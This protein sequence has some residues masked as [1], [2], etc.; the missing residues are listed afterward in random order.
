MDRARCAATTRKALNPSRSCNAPAA[1]GSREDTGQRRSK[2]YSLARVIVR[3]CRLLLAISFIDVAAWAAEAV[4]EG[5]KGQWIERSD[6][7][8]LNILFD[9]ARGIAIA[10]SKTGKDGSFARTGVGRIE[11]YGHDE[12][13]RYFVLEPH[14]AASSGLPPRLYYTFHGNDLW[15]TVAEGP[16]KGSHHLIRKQSK[17][18]GDSR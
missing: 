7:L 5:L 8:E 16:M 2:S 6:G 9:E 1:T 12:H 15:L 4:S 3:V 18:S 11:T 14:I 17:R 13:G 10:A